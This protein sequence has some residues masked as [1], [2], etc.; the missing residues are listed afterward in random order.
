MAQKQGRTIQAQ[1]QTLF[2]EGVTAGLT[3]GQL[4]ERFTTRR[5]PAAEQAFASLVERHGPMVLGA[6]RKILRDDHQAEDAVQA[7]FLV[8][9]HKGGSLWVQDS[10]G[11]WL[12]RVACRIAVRA[13]IAKN[14]SDDAERSVA[15]SPRSHSDNKGPDLLGQALHEEIDRLPAIYRVPVVLCGLEGRT[16][17][18]AARH[19]GCPVGTV[20]S[21]LARGRLRLRKHLARRGLDTPAGL[22]AVMP[23]PNSTKTTVPIVLADSLVQTAM[24]IATGTTT[25]GAVPT[26]VATLT[27]GMMKMMSRSKLACCVGALVG[28][29]ILAVGMGVLVC[30]T[31]GAP[32]EVTRGA[33]T[34]RAAAPI[35]KNDDPT[36]KEPGQTGEIIARVANI[37]PDALGDGHTISMVAIDPETAKWRTI[38]K[39]LPPG[40]VSPDGRFIVYQQLGLDLDEAN[41]GI[42]V[43]DTTGETPPRR[44]FERNGIPSWSHDGKQVVIGTPPAGPKFE[45]WRVNADGS[46]RS[47]LPIPET[48][49]VFDCSRDGTWLATRTIGSDPVHWGRL[50]LVHPDGTGAQY[51]TEGSAKKDVFNIF[52]ISPDGQRIAY[53]EVKAENDIRKCRLFVMDLKDRSRREIPVAFDP[54]TTANVCWSPDGSRLALNPMN[55]HTKEGAI[56]L[57]DLDGKNVRTVPLPPGQWNL[58]VCD[59]KA[60][61]PGLRVG[62]F[63][64][65]SRAG[66]DTPRGRFQAL[67]EEVKK[68][69][70]FEP[71]RFVGRFLEL[72]ESAPEDR[73]AVDAWIWIV[74][75]GSDG[76]ECHRAIDR[77]ADRHAG[78][79][80][81]ANAAL[82]LSFST[83]LSAEKLLR[84]VIEKNPVRHKQ[85]LAYLTWI[86]HPI[87][88]GSDR[89]TIST[90]RP[91]HPRPAWSPACSSRRRG[92]DR[93]SSRQREP[94]SSGPRAQ[95][96]AHP[97]PHPSSGRGFPASFDWV[98]SFQHLGI[99]GP[100]R[101]K[102]VCTRRNTSAYGQPLENF[103]HT[104]R[105]VTRTNAPIFKSFR[106]I[107]WHCASAIAV[108]AS[109]SRRNASSNT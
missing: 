80:K 65:L 93:T 67:S 57:V 95:A 40:P 22:L 100:D 48:D 90:A 13:K 92:P 10:L 5:G 76:P 12:H 105:T 63:N 96:G 46:G 98:S 103:T 52:R 53:V 42:W 44:I 62:D 29:G 4:L 32:P 54:D 79:A 30:R 51:L 64:E 86:S 84:A 39:D 8:L 21:R 11:P 20:K 2:N 18:E 16:Y 9:A 66:A 99:K 26:S 74:T 55:N 25:V 71:R 24:R 27:E 37:A 36:P 58:L 87:L 33:G 107:V 31:A 43:Y 38:A 89:S 3:D 78:M 73:A 77:L 35:V 59:W 97:D 85:G 108:P 41:S 47:K 45:T 1:I 23:T 109:P 101:A 15:E 83:S 34:A 69:N 14:R 106:R 81:V 6:C 104:L 19:L 72:A 68:A 75:F 91:R 49:L 88:S 56:V 17:E 50:T 82:T 60:M 28:V 70:P 7:T 94:G 102:L 61:A